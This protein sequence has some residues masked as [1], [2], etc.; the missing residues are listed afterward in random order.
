MTDER[1]S[2]L[3]SQAMHDWL[4]QSHDEVDVSHLFARLVEQEVLVQ[5]KMHE[6]ER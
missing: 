2:E 5:M 6:D 1:I 4:D 3:W